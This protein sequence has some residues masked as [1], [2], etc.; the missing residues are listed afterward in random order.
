MTDFQSWYTLTDPAPWAA[1][2]WIS[3]RIINPHY[4]YY[5]YFFLKGKICFTFLLKQRQGP[6]KALGIFSTSHRKS[7]SR[8]RWSANLIMS[9]RGSGVFLC[10]Q[11]H[12]S[13]RYEKCVWYIINTRVICQIRLWSINKAYNVPFLIILISLGKFDWRVWYVIILLYEQVL[14]QLTA[15]S[16]RGKKV[17][18]VTFPSCW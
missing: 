5:Y 11:R 15:V 3:L 17:R 8:A 10:P 1:I 13:E 14:I 12:V 18:T 7:E 16:K 9:P 4:Y 6:G 2:G